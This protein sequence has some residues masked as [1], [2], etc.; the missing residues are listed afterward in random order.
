MKDTEIQTM[1]ALWGWEAC[2]V[3]YI[4]VVLAN[5]DGKQMKFVR[6]FDSKEKQSI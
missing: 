3:C 4:I 6:Y 1:F 5:D 2:G